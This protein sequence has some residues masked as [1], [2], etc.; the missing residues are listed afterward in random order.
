MLRR[1]KTVMAKTGLS[2]LG[3]MQHRVLVE[4]E[5]FGTIVLDLTVH[6][7]EMFRD[8]GF[9]A[10]L[11]TRLIPVL[12]TY[13]H[14]KIWHA[15]CAAGEEVYATAITLHEE[16]LL[17]RT[18]IYATDISPRAIEHAKEGVYPERLFETFAANHQAAGGRSSFEE[19]C[20]RA[21]GGMALKEELRKNILF[22][23][24]DLVTDF[25]PGEMHVVFCRNVLIYFGPQLRQRAMTLFAQCLCRGGFLCLGHAE[26]VVQPSPFREFVTPER[27][28]RKSHHA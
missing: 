14:V 28:Y 21:Y 22:F 2:H 3:E 17:D 15:G 26:E 9:F 12:R 18:Q 5:F 8:A 27:I 1:L 10:A 19:H 24:H 20:V 7:S 13:P 6:T 4:P 25:A 23:Q 11:R 16:G